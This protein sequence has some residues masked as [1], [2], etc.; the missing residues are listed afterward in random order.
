MFSILEGFFSPALFTEKLWRIYRDFFIYH[1]IS[2]N[3]AK[4]LQEK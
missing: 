4:K 1:K 3:F 2:V